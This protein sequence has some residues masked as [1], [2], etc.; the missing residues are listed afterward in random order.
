[1]VLCL[2][3]GFKTIN[4]QAKEANPQY[5]FEIITIIKNKG[6]ILCIESYW[7]LL[8]I[9]VLEQKQNRI[10]LVRLRVQCL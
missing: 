4:K 10:N 2:L 7:E 5:L 8:A 6:H 1:M 9:C 3:C